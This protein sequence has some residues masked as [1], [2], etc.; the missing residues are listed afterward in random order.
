[1]RAFWVPRKRCG[2]LVARE[3][4]T[5]RSGYSCPVCQPGRQVRKFAHPWGA[6]AV[7]M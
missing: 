7:G 6:F 2:A 5:N 3:R 1:M 4:F